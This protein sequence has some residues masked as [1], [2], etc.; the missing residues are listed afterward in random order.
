MA[1]HQLLSL[2]EYLRR[3]DDLGN[4]MRLSEVAN[5]DDWTV[6]IPGLGKLLCCPKD[7]PCPP[8]APGPAHAVRRLR[9]A[10]LHGLPRTPVQS[11]AAA[12]EP[13]QRHV[14]QLL[15]GAA[16]HRHGADLR[17]PLRDHPLGPCE[18]PE[19]P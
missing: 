16:A 3:Y 4:N 17:E 14:D 18:A 19:R 7:H 9:S 15:A 6:N 8:R 5:F 1:L 13:L 12:A 11:R 10:P 2:D